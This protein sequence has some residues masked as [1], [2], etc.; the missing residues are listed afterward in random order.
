[1]RPYACPFCDVTYANGSN[2]RTHKKKCHPLELA[3]MEASGNITT[4]TAIPNTKYLQPLSSSQLHWFY[5]CIYWKDRKTDFKKDCAEFV[6]SQLLKYTVYFVKKLLAVKW[7]Q[8]GNIPKYGVKSP[9]RD[10]LL[11][12]HITHYLC[13]SRMKNYEI[14][15]HSMSIV[16]KLMTKIF[17]LSP[18]A[19]F[20]WILLY[21]L[22]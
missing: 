1:M 14:L 12:I 19:N 17:K 7:K 5:C 13:S 3:A 2:L 21:T 18:Q 4:T 6:F 22:T 16:R 15:L 11:Q 9:T 10:L 20:I 8:V